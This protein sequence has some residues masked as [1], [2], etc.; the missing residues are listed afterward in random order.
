LAKLRKASI[1]LKVKAFVMEDVIDTFL[2]DIDCYNLYKYS[3]DKIIIY[4][5]PFYRIFSTGQ[6]VRFRLKD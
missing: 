3:N 5:K 1:K 6:K 2:N 4:N